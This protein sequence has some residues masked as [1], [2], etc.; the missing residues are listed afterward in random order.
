MPSIMV[1][2]HGADGLCADLRLDYC[3]ND[4]DFV[5]MIT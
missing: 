3:L 4:F 1:L 5:D 2:Y